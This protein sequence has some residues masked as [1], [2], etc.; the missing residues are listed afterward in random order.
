MLLNLF[1]VLAVLWSAQAGRLLAFELLD[2]LEEQ[3]VLAYGITFLSR[4]VLLLVFGMVVS[5]FAYA[6]FTMY[7]ASPVFLCDFGAPTFGSV[8]IRGLP[9]VSLLIACY[10]EPAPCPSLPCAFD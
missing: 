7:L 5:L 4:L 3:A 10:I 2:A 8:S 9:E 6:L 1:N